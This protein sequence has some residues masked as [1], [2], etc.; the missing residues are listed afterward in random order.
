MV[1]ADG[2]PAPRTAYAHPVLDA[3][4][5]RDGADVFTDDELD[6]LVEDYVAAAVLAQQ[7]GFDF[8]DVKHCHGYLL[9]ELLTRLRP[10]GPLRRRPRRPHPVPAHGRGGHP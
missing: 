7:A 6:E 1:P 2:A 3:S 10:A 8:V 5:R 4:R 9:H